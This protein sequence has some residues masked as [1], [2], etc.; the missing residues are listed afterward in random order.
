[1][2]VDW[3]ALKA[4]LDGEID[5][6]VVAVGNVHTEAARTGAAEQAWQTYLDRQLSL[7]GAIAE[8]VAFT[9]QTASERRGRQDIGGQLMSL[10]HS[11]DEIWLEAEAGMILPAYAE[12]ARVFE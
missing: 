5:Q 9:P 2:I 10:C 7:Q 11:L 12:L 6:F 4:R 8:V 1:V 3:K